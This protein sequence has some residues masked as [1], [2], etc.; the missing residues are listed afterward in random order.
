MKKI[1]LCSL[2]ALSCCYMEACRENRKAKNY[3]NKTMVD[4]AGLKFITNANEAGLTEI[5]AANIALKNSSNA[6][7][8]QF[9]KMMITDHTEMGNKLKKLAA[10]K[11]VSITN[12]VNEEHR[13]MINVLSTKTGADFDKAYMQMMVSDH[14]KVIELFRDG[15]TNTNAAINTLSKD[16]LPKLENHLSEAKKILSTIK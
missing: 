3:N 15:S 14:E 6:Q 8:T 1:L 4:D 9:A 7:V 5:T 10:D 2:I 13:N 16:D 12:S 11:Y